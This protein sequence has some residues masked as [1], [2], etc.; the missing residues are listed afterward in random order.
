MIDCAL[1]RDCRRPVQHCV[2]ASR[3]LGAERL[4]T[5]VRPD[6]Y[7][8][9][10]TDANVAASASIMKAVQADLVLRSARAGDRGSRASTRRNGPEADDG[11]DPLSPS[12]AVTAA[13]LTIA[14]KKPTTRVH[15]EFW[16]FARSLLGR[17]QRRAAGSGR[18]PPAPAMPQF[19]WAYGPPD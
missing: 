2:R 9:S 18:G 13:S 6:R 17:A 5:R 7:R 19:F 16:G 14:G 15:R 11:S 1:Q 10:A 4:D 12:M 8:D 3:V